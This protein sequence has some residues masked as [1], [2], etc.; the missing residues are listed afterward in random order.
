MALLEGPTVASAYRILTILPLLLFCVITSSALANQEQVLVNIEWL[1]QHQNEPDLLLIDAREK[2]D[3]LKGHIPGAINVPVKATYGSSKNIDRVGGLKKISQLF[4]HAGIDNKHQLVVYDGNS[5]IDAGRVFWV[6]EVYG[7][8]NVKLLDGG[9]KGWQAITGQAL[10]TIDVKRE[11]T[12]YIPAI[13]PRRLITKFSMRLALEDKS[14]VII[15][16]RSKKEFAGIESIAHRSGH[17]PNAINIP[18]EENFVEVN[19]IKML[20]PIEQ[21]REIYDEK[22][23]DKKVLLYCNKGKQSSLSYTILRQL[24]HDAAHYDGSWYEWGNDD[25]L[26]IEKNKTLK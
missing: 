12:N 26:P 19:G 25:S 17:I 4:S 24:G 13:E 15:D 8:K 6:L 5:Y 18:W 7:H 3:Y 11:K 22:I 23:G 16:A 2:Q 21:L 1:V 14:K 9:I 10:S 20:K